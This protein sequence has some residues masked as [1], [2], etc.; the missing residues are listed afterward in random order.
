[1]SPKKPSKK[2][3][4][5]NFSMKAASIRSKLSPHVIRVWERRYQAVTPDRTDTQRRLYSEE[6]VERLILL[7]KATEVGHRIGQIAKLSRKELIKLIPPSQVFLEQDGGIS[8]KVPS[9]QVSV[10]DLVE[11]VKNYDVHAFQ[12]GLSRAAVS[13]SRPH[14][15]EQVIVPLIVRVGDLW[16]EGTLRVAQEHFATSTVRSFVGNLNGAVNLPANAPCLVV[17]TPAGQVHEMGALMASAT[18]LT[19]GW[20]VLY[21][22]PNLPVE[23]ICSAVE[24]NGARAVALSIVYPSND[25][26]INEE[27]LKIRR[28]LPTHVALIVGG[29]AAGSYRK[30]LEE[31]KA[32]VLPDVGSL[33][34]CLDDLS[35]NRVK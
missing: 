18:A 6:D 20:R 12:E 30:V 2:K 25:T 27:L 22:G 8:P 24:Q 23:E 1:M 14:L 29:R 5:K 4:V 33:R 3:P 31:I 19:M 21:L 11:A 35:T 28:L 16:Q 26:H 13:L 34:T 9:H 15:I 10:D 17:T 32:I 7:R